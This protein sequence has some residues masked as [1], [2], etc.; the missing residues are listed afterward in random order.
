MTSLFGLRILALHRVTHPLVCLLLFATVVNQ[1]DGQQQSEQSRPESNR[2]ALQQRIEERLAVLD[3]KENAHASNREVGYQ[4]SRLGEDYSLAGEFGNAES[5]FNHAV[6]SFSKEPG[7][8]D[9][10]AGAL[11]E[12]GALYRIYGRIPEALNCRRKALTLREKLHDPLQLA[13]SQ[14][15]LAELALISNKYKEAF[16]GADRAYRQMSGMENAGKVDLLSA[17]LVRTYAKCRLRRRAECLSDAQQAFALSRSAFAEGSMPVGAALMALS[18]AQLDNGAALEAESSARRAWGILNRELA[19]DDPRVIFAM[20]Q[21][22][23]C[24]LALDRKEEAQKID[25]EVSA[26]HREP[27]QPCASCTV[28]VYGLRVADH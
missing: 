25:A 7:D 13:L 18:F 20:S 11:D 14:S 15:H 10:Y 4:W 24:L 17:L 26:I 3:A 1:S 5:A 27:A 8:R 28:S 2:P 9:L 12:L 16:T 22:R 6:E 21:D 19:S 23:D